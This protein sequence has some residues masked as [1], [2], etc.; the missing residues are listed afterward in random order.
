MASIYDLASSGADSAKDT[1]FATNYG[2]LPIIQTP[3][4]SN[5]DLFVRGLTAYA[6][7][8]KDEQ[9][10][11]RAREIFGDNLVDKKHAG[12]WVGEAIVN[13]SG[14]KNVI[15][16]YIAN[17]IP[18]PDGVTDPDQLTTTLGNRILAEFS[19]QY[20]Q[21]KAASE[22]AHNRAVTN[23]HKLINDKC[24]PADLEDAPYQEIIDATGYSPHDIYA[25]GRI[26]AARKNQNLW[27]QAAYL[28]ST[29]NLVALDTLYRTVEA[30]GAAGRGNFSQAA[31]ILVRGSGTPVDR[32][33]KK[34]GKKADA[35]FANNLV[36]DAKFLALAKNPT[37]AL[38]IVQSEAYK[39][40][41]KLLE[42][43]TMIGR[44]A[45]KIHDAAQNVYQGATDLALTPFGI[46]DNLLGLDNIDPR[47]SQR[48]SAAVADAEMQARADVQ[49]SRGILGGI[50]A[51][52]DW[53]IEN[54]AL[55]NPYTAVSSTA[56]LFR[57]NAGRGFNAIAGEDGS[58][59]PSVSDIS[60]YG[61]AAS[62]TII[63][64]LTRSWLTK[65]LPPKISKGLSKVGVNSSVAH[66]FANAGVTG[67]EFATLL[68][69]SDGYLRWFYD[70]AY[71]AIFGLDPRLA[72]GEKAVKQLAQ[73]MQ[74]PKHWLAAYTAGFMS[75]APGMPAYHRHG[76]VLSEIAQCRGL[77]REEAETIRRSTPLQDQPKAFQDK[78]NEKLRTNPE[79]ALDAMF[80]NM[81]RINSEEQLRLKRE[82]GMQ[83]ETDAAKL[84]S[85]KMMGITLADGK[86]SNHVKIVSGGNID[87]VT[88]KYIEG[89]S[90]KE[91][92]REDAMLYLGAVF[93]DAVA[94][95]A[96]AMRNNYANTKIKDV[97]DSAL[98]GKIDI[99]TMMDTVDFDKIIQRGKEAESLIEQRV[100]ELVEK[101]KNED[102]KP[103]LAESDART[104]AS[105]E[106]NKSL[107]KDFTLADLVSFGKNAETRREQE[108][109]RKRNLDPDKPLSTKAFVVT[110]GNRDDNSLRRILMVTPETST[111]EWAEE[112]S[113]MWLDDYMTNERL[114]ITDVWRSVS[115]LSDHIIANKPNY[116][117][118]R[119][120]LTTLR[121]SNPE[122]A[123][124]LDEGLT[125][126][127]NISGD[128]LMAINK[129]VREAFSVMMLSNLREL[130]DSLSS[131]IADWARP[132]LN[133]AILNQ[134]RM[135]QE[136]AYGKA[137]NDAALV[138]NFDNTAMRLLGLTSNKL[139]QMLNEIQA[140]TVD[141]YIETYRKAAEEYQNLFADPNSFT[142]EQT[143]ALLAEMNEADA[144]AKEAKRQAKAEEE[145]VI[146]EAINEAAQDPANQG[147]TKEEV[148]LKVDD[149]IMQRKQDEIAAAPNHVQD[150]DA[151]NGV[152][153]ERKGKDGLT[154]RYM[155]L[156]INR[157]EMLPNFKTG[158]DAET[159]EVTKLTGAFRRDHDP[160]RVLRTTDG[161]LVLISGRHRFNLAKRHERDTIAA[162]V[163]EQNEHQTMEWAKRQDI[164]WNI[165]D[166]Q[167]RP[168][169]VA[170]FIRGELLPELPPLDLAEV[171]RIGITRGLD[172]NNFSANSMKGYILAV[173]ATP[174][175][176][177]A[178]R[179]EI[180][181]E[182]QALYISLYAPLANL[183]TMEPVGNRNINTMVQLKGLAYAADGAG[184]N[185]TIEA[186]T[187]ERTRQMHL[188]QIGNGL[189]S[190]WF[191][192]LM[193]DDTYSNFVEEYSF[194]K[195]K[196]YAKMQSQRKAIS[197][198][199]KRDYQTRKQVTDGTGVI[200]DAAAHS[201][202]KNK[203]KKG[204]PQENIDLWK[205]P[206]LN[207]DVIGEE[208]NK[209]FAEAYPEKWAE[210]QERKAAEEAATADFSV[211]DLQAWQVDPTRGLGDL[212]HFSAPLLGKFAHVNDDIVDRKLSAFQQIAKRR[213]RELRHI[214]GNSDVNM[215]M[216]EAQALIDNIIT[217]L[218]RDYSF[219]REPYHM[220][221]NVYSS[222]RKDGNPIT[223][224]LSLPMNQWPEIMQH[225]FRNQFE[226]LLTDKMKPSER[227][228]FFELFDE[229]TVKADLKPIYD[230]YIDQR[231]KLV[232]EVKLKWKD[233]DKKST[234]AQKRYRAEL[235]K[236]RSKASELTNAQ[237]ADEVK[238]AYQAI[239][240]A[241]LHRIMDKMLSRI[242]LKLDQY[243]KN[244]ILTKIRKTFA[245][246]TPR[247]Q[248]DGKPVKGTVDMDVY[249]Q[250]L[251]AYRLLL[252]TP[253]Q[254][255][256]IDE[257]Y[258][259]KA[260]KAKDKGE[261]EPTTIDVS[262]FDESGNP[263]EFTV[264]TEVYNTYSCIQT[265]NA[266]TAI[267]AQQA[268]GTLVATGK[269]AWEVKA[270]L[271]R[272]QLNDFCSPIYQRYKESGDEQLKRAHK[273]TLFI[274]GGK[275]WLEAIRRMLTG[276]MNDAAL[277]DTIAVM[278]GLEQFRTVQ[279]RIAS[280]HGYI[281]AAEKQNQLNAIKAALAVCGFPDADPT[282]LTAEE[283]VAY[284]NFLDDINDTKALK[285]KSITLTEQAP[286]FEQQH[287][288]ALRLSVLSRLN[289]VTKKKDFDANKL[290]VVIN[291]LSEDNTMP[292]SLME[293]V[294]AK[295]GV[296]VD[297]EAAE[298]ID[299]AAAME[300][301]FPAVKY[302]HMRNLNEAIR[303]RSAKSMQ[304]WLNPKAAKLR[305]RLNSFTLNKD[306]NADEFVTVLSYAL[307]K[308]LAPKEVLQ[309][310]F[311][312]H[313]KAERNIER[314]LNGDEIPNKKLG[315]VQQVTAEEL[316]KLVD[317]YMPISKLLPEL[318]T[319]SLNGLSKEEL[320]E[321]WKELPP[322]TQ[323]L[324]EL[325]KNE[326]AYRVLLTE[327]TDLSDS[328]RKQGY[329]PEVVEQLKAFAGEK[330]MS[331][332]YALRDLMNA[333]I[334]TLQAI[335]EATYGTPF[336]AV[337]NYFRAFFDAGTK[338]SNDSQLEGY[339]FG[340][341]GKNETGMRLFNTR[342]KHNAPIMPNMDVTHAFQIGM[343]QQ[344]N[345]IA[346][347]DPISHLHLGEFLRKVL[348]NRKGKTK[349]STVLDNALGK[350]VHAA[351]VE[352]VENMYRIYGRTDAFNSA[353]NRAVR[354]IGAAGAVA[355]LAGRTVS[356]AKN[357]MAYFN[358]LG[359]SDFV[360]P[361]DWAKSAARLKLFGTTSHGFDISKDPLIT[362]R[363]K[364]WDTETMVE[365]L[366]QQA[367]VK[368]S[369]SNINRYARRGLSAFGAFDRWVTARSAAV[370]YDATYRKLQKQ[371][372]EYDANTLHTLS[373]E[374]AAMALGVKGQP[375]DYRQR[376]LMSTRNSFL[377]ASYYFLG[378]E[379]WSTFGDCT[380]LAIKSIFNKNVPKEQRMHALANLA[381][382][383]LVNGF[384]YSALSYFFN[385]LLDD[386]EHWNRRSAAG[387]LVIGSLF[388]PI[389][390]M[391]IISNLASGALRGT[392]RL[393]GVNTPYISTPSYLPMADIERSITEFR[394]LWSSKAST[395]D[396]LI[397]LENS[398]RNIM[399]LVLVGTQRPTSK[400]GVYAKSASLVGVT[401]LN[402]ID[403][404]LRLGRAADER[405][406]E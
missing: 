4:M 163:Y 353:A 63:N 304:D 141:T 169:D 253:T 54:A 260:D 396:K 61:K 109:A 383:W 187:M 311:D 328:L 130:S 280:A 271:E 284:R 278:P 332:A 299:M 335:W 126:D 255:D 357:V 282:N 229:K 370:M 118:T 359:G 331:F 362:D 147:L 176:I 194:K 213:I 13:R 257:A 334:D 347:S 254:K 262:T 245:S 291:R 140:P 165:A 288:D 392:G 160:V 122:L 138:G 325:T 139:K 211:A 113:E 103:S 246:I 234:E 136:A 3:E 10:A 104:Q 356:L 376:P 178:L 32:L 105:S 374:A 179:N 202:S 252:L 125:T 127:S 324:T 390:G 110:K 121:K 137:L 58:I 397:S 330:M 114:D 81:K 315:E 23:F 327:Q 237:F 164:E 250:A 258:Q 391:P 319:E 212:G 193:Q 152:A 55:V 251:T 348:A 351:L 153:E 30:A 123:K 94:N 300:Y 158:A 302:G 218:P 52:F 128:D 42:N 267:K 189:Q 377:T 27:D 235:K 219:G 266:E 154:Y 352:H 367:G 172:E 24:T 256:A 66:F 279:R 28:T 184:K 365:S 135:L 8:E 91:F 403:F 46:A 341:G 47:Q 98:D 393:I 238:V 387:S 312:K 366:Y 293:E 20:D 313:I 9:E 385:A 340:A 83:I 76:V 223:A 1:N 240:E 309:P 84:A 228:L 207:M 144:R 318:D 265:M 12:F 45:F 264:S 382:V 150:A 204:T 343:K 21:R 173:A 75:A 214:H 395:W 88:G 216:G 151:V 11:A 386:E 344:D 15:N 73:D 364:E 339:A 16:A 404:L 274:S 249:E 231:T 62:S 19:Y 157:L 272:Q 86:D 43:A 133:A 232:D 69:F 51:G 388:G 276:T 50:E 116:T 208:I 197:D 174:D 221:S 320:A 349:M 74:T 177:T 39:K 36:N 241:R 40:E 371:N 290:G 100:K 406:L 277:I 188:A 185:M 248:K 18:I 72:D 161:R 29:V 25:A 80:E 166:D 378:G 17:N 329:T 285:D 60:V 317:K 149:E 247:K 37:E 48:V 64:Y 292:S 220:F 350:P 263:I 233:R 368:S 2:F 270:N 107:H 225:A 77:S 57:D 384:A 65:Y 67:T 132:L 322:E 261:T 336:P 119:E 53:G 316:N 198:V 354:D 44:M 230:F 273:E 34:Q 402:A 269:Q 180:I 82:V 242:V 71:D 215:I 145:A 35:A 85:L 155:I 186:M 38:K 192:F 68:P 236:A 308:N 33:A 199:A 167:A 346:Y 93:D 120:T 306:F 134:H 239:G 95:L 190:D 399:F 159:G 310:F 314:D 5:S 106:I 168:L 268:L 142:S 338:E 97:L 22:A 381:A 222:L 90:S 96:E 275:G 201:R 7:M 283:L 171:N 87:P 379:A 206:W 112:I 405:W 259:A 111:R 49:D 333:R 305:K 361:L 196:D 108:A 41:K 358:T 298:D 337:E 217:A 303:E 117:I 224:P 287:L 115:A 398:I 355:I 183:K 79:A 321:L 200:V 227:E 209:A 205:N 281:E 401:A 286:N 101:S 102:G 369:L 143:D 175:I 31:R 244:R 375:L 342:I 6:N 363:F 307:S 301:V 131:D 295:Y 345:L 14:T 26:L 191:G 181:G 210:M 394:H 373:L 162:F 243:R 156:D 70:D 372:P 78:L 296:A 99:V 92:T 146:D 326:A 389:A 148:A 323:T 289:D 203:N 297:P 56:S 380:R 360:N 400:A 124:R 59:D 226:R 89:S 182:E 129:D 195:R 294:L 170:L